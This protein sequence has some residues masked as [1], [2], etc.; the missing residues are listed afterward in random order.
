MRSTWPSLKK[1]FRLVVENMP[2][3]ELGQEPADFAY[4]YAGYAPLSV[5]LLHAMVMQ[6]PSLAESLKPLPGP[7]FTVKQ[8]VAGVAASTPPEGSVGGGG[9]SGAASISSGGSGGADGGGSDE[10]TRPPLTLV[11]FVGGCTF[12][13]IAALRWLGR[14]GQP[15]R[16]YLIVTTHICNGDAM[17]DSLVEPC[18]NDLERYDD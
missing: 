11:F 14:N 3:H 15:R 2:D 12:A 13:E 7:Y 16:D 18:E 4:V 6:P 1:A 10:G 17:M 8:P 5:R 9:K